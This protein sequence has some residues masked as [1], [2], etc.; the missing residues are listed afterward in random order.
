MCNNFAI[1]ITSDSVI[2]FMSVYLRN[3]Q[4]NSW[5]PIILATQEAEVR[6]IMIQ[7]QPGEIV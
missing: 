7:S 1:P 5:E 3:S 4:K 2:P 6:R